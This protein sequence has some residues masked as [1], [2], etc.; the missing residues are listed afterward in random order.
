[1]E[2]SIKNLAVY[3][4]IFAAGLGA[5]YVLTRQKPAAATART[6]AVPVAQPQAANGGNG[7][8]P[9]DYPT[10]WTSGYHGPV[11]GIYPEAGVAERL[12]P[13]GSAHKVTEIDPATY[14][15]SLQALSAATNGGVI[16][17]D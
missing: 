10:R 5:G 15:A 14:N 13:Y 6:A 11:N 8:L 12:F 16:F 2:I 1:M 9:R 7:E 3:G 17:V 4:A